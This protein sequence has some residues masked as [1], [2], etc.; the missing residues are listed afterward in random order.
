MSDASTPY[1]DLDTEVWLAL[2]EKGIYQA[3]EYLSYISAEG[4]YQF[5][6]GPEI[7]VDEMEEEGILKGLGATKEE[8]ENYGPWFRMEEEGV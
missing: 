1:E 8:L 2:E 4:G 7:T 5:Y 3:V 6:L